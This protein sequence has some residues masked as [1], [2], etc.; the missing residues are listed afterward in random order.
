MMYSRTDVLHRVPRGRTVKA[1]ARARLAPY[2]SGAFG[3]VVLLLLM[4]F[5][6][7]TGTFSPAPKPAEQPLLPADQVTVS[8]STITGLDRQN[9]PY[10]I[11]ARSAVQDKDKPNLIALDDVS[12]ASNIVTS[13]TLMKAATIQ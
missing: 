12:G 6:Y 4:I 8:D 2:V 5:L 10:S 3:G 1:A 9:Q 7:Q 11:S 13:P